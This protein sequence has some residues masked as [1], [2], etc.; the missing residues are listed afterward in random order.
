MRACRARSEFAGAVWRTGEQDWGVLCAFGDENYGV[1]FYTVAHG[2]H[3]LAARIVPDVLRN[4]ELRGCFICESGFRWFLR[5]VL[6]RHTCCQKKRG[7][8]TDQN[9][10]HATADGW[11]HRNSSSKETARIC[12]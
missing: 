9:R 12:S 2:N 5:R 3:D 6:R 8:G 4:L 10:K 11:C 1:E 7:Y